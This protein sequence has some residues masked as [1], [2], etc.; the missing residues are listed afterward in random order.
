MKKVIFLI[1]ILLTCIQIGYS[2]TVDEVLGLDSVKI[3]SFYKDSTYTV[4][5]R[6]TISEHLTLWGTDPDSIRVFFYDTLN[7]D[8][9]QATVQN[10]NTCMSGFYCIRVEVTFPAAPGIDRWQVSVH[11][12]ASYNMER[13]GDYGL[14]DRPEVILDFDA[15]VDSLRISYPYN[16]SS[17]LD[18]AITMDFLQVDGTTNQG[19]VSS[20]T[21]FGNYTTNV[22]KINT[23][24]Y[25]F[26]STNMKNGTKVTVDIPDS[27]LYVNLN[28]ASA[29]YW[30]P[31][32]ANIPVKIINSPYFIQRAEIQPVDSLLTIYFN[33][34]IDTS[35][36][37]NA[38]K[39]VIHNGVFND[40]LYTPKDNMVYSGDSLTHAVFQLPQLPTGQDPNGWRL[41]IPASSLMNWPNANYNF[42]ITHADS[43][44]IQELPPT[45][46][47]LDSAFISYNPNYGLHLYWS[48]SV[49]C[50]SPVVGVEIKAYN[51]GVYQGSHNLGSRP[52]LYSIVDT[53]ITLD[54]YAGSDKT[55]LQSWIDLGYDLEVTVPAG[56]CVDTSS[57]VPVPQRSSN[58]R[59]NDEFYSVSVLNNYDT[60]NTNDHYFFEVFLANTEG[61]PE[62]YTLSASTD[63]Q[64]IIDSTSVLFHWSGTRWLMEVTT[65]PNTGPVN[66][67]VTSM[68]PI[69]GSTVS[70]NQLNMWASVYPQPQFGIQSIEL[71]VDTNTNEKMLSVHYSHF[72]DFID[73]LAF[74][75]MAFSDGSL[76]T[77]LGDI[78]I[79]ATDNWILD[80]STMYA[81][82]R[83]APYQNDTIQQWLNDSNTV[84]FVTRDNQVQSII[85]YSVLPAMLF[86]VTDTIDPNTNDL[87]GTEVLHLPY[88]ATMGYLWYKA[89]E[90][91]MQNSVV[92]SGVSNAPG[93]F[94]TSTSTRYSDMYKMPYTIGSVGDATVKIKALG[95]MFPDS[96]DL[97]VKVYDPTINAYH[98]MSPAL[99]DTVPQ[100][101]GTSFP[102]KVET[103]YSLNGVS[104]SATG[105]ATIATDS[106]V[107]DSLG[108]GEWNVTVASG[109]NT[110]Q[111]TI[112][113]VLTHSVY[114]ELTNSSHVVEVE[115]INANVTIGAY[116]MLMNYENDQYITINAGS[117]FALSIDWAN[118][119]VLSPLSVSIDSSSSGVW[120]LHVTPSN[121]EW[122]DAD[123]IISAHDTLGNHL[124]NTLLEVTIYEPAPVY[125]NTFT[126]GAFDTILVQGDVR[127][128]SVTIDP[129]LSLTAVSQEP[130]VLQDSSIFVTYISPGQ[131][132]VTVF[133]TPGQ[134][135]ETNLLIDTY[136]PGNVWFATHYLG[137][138][139]EQDTTSLG[140]DSNGCVG[141]CMDYGT[142]YFNLFNSKIEFIFNENI[143]VNQVGAITLKALKFD[144]M[145]DMSPVILDEMIIPIPIGTPVNQNRI[146][147]TLTEF[148]KD[149]LRRID[150]L[151]E[152]L[153]A[154]VDAGTFKG[155]TSNTVNN[156][157]GAFVEVQPGAKFQLYSASFDPFE[158][159]ITFRFDGPVNTMNLNPAGIFRVGEAPNGDNGIDISMTYTAWGDPNCFDCNAIVNEV[160]VYLTEDEFIAFE[161]F[162]NKN[163]L[164]VNLT[165][166]FLSS[167]FNQPLEESTFQEQIPLYYGV[168]YG[169]N[170]IENAQFDYEQMKLSITLNQDIQN[171]FTISMDTEIGITTAFAIFGVREDSSV[172][173][174]LPDETANNFVYLR[175]GID[176]IIYDPLSYTLNIDIAT[177]NAVEV[178][179]WLD[180][181]G[182]DA[183]N[184]LIIILPH[185]A[186]ENSSGDLN[187]DM[188]HRVLTGENFTPIDTTIIDTTVIDTTLIDTTLI[189]TTLGDTTDIPV[190]PLFDYSAPEVEVKKF[191]GVAYF[192]LGTGEQVNV[193][194]KASFTTPAIVQYETYTEGSRVYLEA[195]TY[196]H[197]VRVEDSLYSNAATISGDAYTA[198]DLKVALS[199]T[200]FKIQFLNN[201]TDNINNATFKYILEN[202]S[203]GIVDTVIDYTVS[204]IELFGFT[205]DSI[206]VSA[207]LQSLEGA[208]SLFIE[209]F[210]ID[211]LV[212]L[213]T[214]E[215]IMPA[216]ERWQMVSF[217]SESFNPMSLNETTALFWWDDNGV[218][219]LLFDRYVSKEDL[220]SIQPGQGVWVSTEVAE[221][222]SLAFDTAVVSVDLVA[223]DEGWNLVGNPYGFKLLSSAFGNVDLFKW[224]GSNY[225]Q[226]NYLEPGEGYWAT[227]SRSETIELERKVAWGTIAERASDFTFKTAAHSQSNWEL[228]LALKGVNNDLE[229]AYN[230]IGVKPLAENS[231][232]E[233]DK[234]ELPAAMGESI[235]LSF[236][237]D[238][239]LFRG[240]YKS[241]IDEQGVWNVNMGT[242]SDTPMDAL[243]TLQGLEDVQSLGYSVYLVNGSNQIEITKPEQEVTLNG[244][245]SYSLVV[246]EGALNSSL[247]IARASVTN[248]PNPLRTFT[249]IMLNKVDNPGAFMHLKVFTVTGELLSNKRLPY[250]ESIHWEPVDSKGTLLNSGMYFYEITTGAT[251]VR[252]K[253]LIMD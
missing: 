231:I 100:F 148:Q 9:I 112:N 191:D 34:K 151:S 26:I 186:I 106:I 134:W 248:F 212:V 111:E 21:S 14:F 126:V 42:A 95:G 109:G 251:T 200:A 240:D 192:V 180:I 130:N 128:I 46:I 196:Y 73:T 147:M 225:Y 74:S 37:I 210:A 124:S 216:I 56:A 118:T 161:K 189:D 205:G 3:P 102:I 179:S 170:W 85:D 10:V 103:L 33:E 11:S 213:N 131:W 40:T 197:V 218:F 86:T 136:A 65:G 168:D 91:S 93:V 132:D 113:M 246:S 137:V 96:L 98:I 115:Q 5:V 121:N 80:D 204:H 127:V 82:I 252:N 78:P 48:D 19:F 23:T 223:G 108:N 241:T 234:R 117:E 47:T 28:G 101:S 89:F 55:S 87:V 217:G 25:S 166:G 145:G 64:N 215:S 38:N 155:T 143:L 199:E 249:T 67:T 238:G 90:S 52:V 68:S 201:E 110:G 153:E 31:G 247:F 17:T 114:G 59:I 233:S 242:S 176:G 39:W 169:K 178:D 54:W 41:E 2:Q 1:I 138:T 30:N 202:K 36:T 107:V 150:L 133:T 116:N 188:A 184:E 224:D 129:N 222:V 211:T 237:Q 71:A 228:G 16:I 15:G 157:H 92:V 97:H 229:D 187:I 75:I 32:L 8:T 35:S 162:P 235:T 193:S 172:V 62:L 236:V 154:F 142:F 160:T 183:T 226:V 57:Q 63:N 4:L 70:S 58:F 99:N 141:L 83:L 230:S 207:A 227:V 206:K 182:I 51:S 122:G 13:Y 239:K 243:L 220:S 120:L 164:I 94:N 175:D 76:N 60:L 221:V 27:L 181:Y 144:F 24:P 244:V 125:Q 88:D 119:T 158:H 69:D 66:L 195:K 20:W 173:H 29:Y 194:N 22:L 167:D 18:K 140:P 163:N 72:V 135:G 61:Q 77:N 219:D 171:H 152:H 174:G 81:K 104:L 198:L 50:N 44:H 6:S 79:N 203:L 208:D 43:F 84:V 185:G 159:A 214:I 105:G 209:K 53:V 250:S 190:N 149:E 7:I 12:S 49:K 45:P 177:S 146:E 139:I 165:N 253:M 156:Y 123:I 232:D 245:Q